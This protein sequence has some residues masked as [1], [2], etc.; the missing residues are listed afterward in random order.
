MKDPD[1]CSLGV[2]DPISVSVGC[3]RFR[4]G[5][6]ARPLGHLNFV[7][8]DMDKLTLSGRKTCILMAQQP[9]FRDIA[10]S[11]GPLTFWT[12]GEVDLKTALSK[13]EH[14][15]QN[16]FLLILKNISYFLFL[17]CY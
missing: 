3:H 4:F 1:G 15:F 11:Q 8:P 9:K 5:M 10:Q 14:V 2:L 6:W 16:T 17:F 13:A 12:W 7:D